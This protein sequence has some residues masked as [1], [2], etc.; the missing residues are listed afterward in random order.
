MHGAP[1]ETLIRDTWLALNVSHPRY[2]LGLP[3]PTCLEGRVFHSSTSHLNVSTFCA[4]RWV[5]FIDGNSSG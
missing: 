3:V 1:L 5:G 2:L 4:I